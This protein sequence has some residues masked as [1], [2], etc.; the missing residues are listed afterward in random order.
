MLRSFFKKIVS[1]KLFPSVLFIITALYVVT[2]LLIA[3]QYSMA[4]A[5]S[6]DCGMAPCGY[7]YFSH[8]IET[9]TRLQYNVLP[10]IYDDGVDAIPSYINSGQGLWDLLYN[11]YTSQGAY[12]NLSSWDKTRSRIGAAFIAETMLGVT[13]PESYPITS[14]AW[15]NLENLLRQYSTDPSAKLRIIFNTNIDTQYNSRYVSFR[16]GAKENDDQFIYRA[17][18]GSGIKFLAPDKNGRETV[19]YRI[20]Y[21]CANPGGEPSGIP[22]VC[23]GD[24]CI[25]THKSS[26][27]P[28]S[29]LI[30]KIVTS[31]SNNQ[32]YDV[33]QAFSSVSGQVYNTGPSAS[34]YRK[35]N[36]GSTRLPYG[37]GTVDYNT[38]AD[39]NYFDK[40]QLTEVIFG[41]NYDKN[42]IVGATNNSNDS[43]EGY[44]TGNGGNVK[45]TW[46][47]S[48]STISGG[49]TVPEQTLQNLK[50][51]D[52]ESG[53]R[54]CFGMSVHSSST[55][56]VNSQV[57]VNQNYN[58]FCDE[59]DRY[60]DCVD[61]DYSVKDT[62][63]QETEPNNQWAHSGLTC[64]VVG[65]HP[66]FNVTNGD[67]VV[68]RTDINSPSTQPQPVDT[69]SVMKI[70][71]SQKY[72]F[73][74][75][76]QYA[77]AASG[78][79]SGMS[80]NSGLNG[81]YVT[82]NIS[83][84]GLVTSSID[85]CSYSKL[86]LANLT[87]SSHIPS[88]LCQSSNI[89]HYQVQTESP[90]WSKYLLGTSI[91][92]NI[93]TNVNGAVNYVNGRPSGKYVY[94]SN[95]GNY[96]LSSSTLNS[97]H[98]LILYTPNAT[99]T[100]S[101]DLNY[102]SGGVSD[103]YKLPQLIIVAKNINIE[104]SASNVNAWLYASNALN[105]C[106][107]KG[108]NDR[109]TNND[110]N[111]K[112]TINGTVITKYIYLRRTA[113]SGTTIDASGDP[114]E[115]FNYD[116]NS[117]LWA[118]SNGNRNNIRTVYQEEISPRF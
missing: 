87:G 40:W 1:D 75:W 84:G 59:Y 51:D 113:G 60:G 56:T 6:Y 108:T 116:T 39:E 20:F 16:S 96:N 70:E 12:A 19:V 72:V 106:S 31:F 49:N 82:P 86:T 27:A 80:S 8:V 4:K 37:L 55:N 32:A 89:G 41:P 38:Y 13:G 77:I 64:L 110:C 114:A 98:S 63:T 53:S 34:L 78:G 57:H 45:Q 18:S 76:A 61:Y 48:G 54:I 104:N 23:V 74:S 26:D 117:I 95:I 103:A 69:S 11:A 66:K 14:S 24:S 85:M 97:G 94:S 91:Q 5:V 36:Y 115:V 65:K 71:D 25:S 44:Y 105:T 67:L 118:M 101:G 15:S 52:L 83:T 92:E 22:P 46:K 17:H 100:I 88:L 102:N 7:A 10:A 109:L 2:L 99:V 28:S 68:G 29:R 30:P 50:V 107:D 93:N 9:T 35:I 90:S 21:V 42:N 3:G 43:P 81:G 47:G 33:S 62:I 112:L 111:N 73:G 58:V 79:V